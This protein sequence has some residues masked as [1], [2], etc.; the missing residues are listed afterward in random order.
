M[1]TSLIRVISIN[2]EDS[3]YQRP[4]K[5]PKKKFDLAEASVTWEA[6]RLQKRRQKRIKV[7]DSQ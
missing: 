2:S 7:D 5:R 6:F 4:K 1:V 3:T